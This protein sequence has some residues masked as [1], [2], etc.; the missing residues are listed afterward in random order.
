[1]EQFDAERELVGNLAFQNPTHE[2]VFLL[3]RP[4]LRF[5]EH[6]KVNAVPFATMPNQVILT[7]IS[8]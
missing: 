4:G 3:P 5:V 2:Q 6:G 7:Q 1:V 8:N